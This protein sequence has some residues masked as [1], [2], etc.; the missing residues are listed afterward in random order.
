MRQLHILLPALREVWK[1]LAKAYGT[2][3]QQ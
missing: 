3:A 1:V 2:Q